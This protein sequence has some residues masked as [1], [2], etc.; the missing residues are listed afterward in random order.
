M[1]TPQ[2]ET[3]KRAK[4]AFRLSIKMRNALTGYLFVLPWLVGLFIF[5]LYPVVLSIQ[6]SFS[7]TQI[8][9]GGFTRTFY[10]WSAYKFI[11]E[12]DLNFKGYLIEDLK[13]LAMALVVVLVFSLIVA[14]LLNG[15]FLFR[16]LF[17]LVFF[18][19]VIVLSGPIFYELMG[20]S[21]N[22]NFIGDELLYTIFSIMPEQMIAVVTFILF[23]L[24]GCMWF[25]GVQVL[26][27]LAGLQKIDSALFEAAQIDGAGKWECFWKITLPAM[28]NLILINAV[29]TVIELANFS[30]NSTGSVAAAW[31][32]S[33][34]PKLQ[35]NRMTT[36]ILG[37]IGD[38]THP[39]SMA[40]ALSWMYF[41]VILAVLLVVF[42]V[43]K[44]FDGRD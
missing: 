32:T 43:F 19:P 18:L 17:R 42:L 41:L 7:K 22:F 40:A 4:S 21:D 27:F 33:R 44:I 3:P 13:F 11:W 5:A 24:V 2:I 15:K 38:T 39:Y 36:H 14:V 37:K 30:S 1:Q 25:A 10:G 9:P 6:I 29:Y 16:G 28:K 31:D 12:E 34:A 23:S 26:I 8:G 35:P 20:R